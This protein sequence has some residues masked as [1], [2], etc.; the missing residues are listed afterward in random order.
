[1]NQQEPKEVVFQNMDDL[2]LD[3][4]DNIL[5]LDEAEYPQSLA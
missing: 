2:D 1:M 3:K 5:E 4:Y